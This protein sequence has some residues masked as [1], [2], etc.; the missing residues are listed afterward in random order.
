MDTKKSRTFL[1]SRSFTCF[2]STTT[3]WLVMRH[4]TLHRDVGTLNFA[5]RVYKH[6]CVWSHFWISLHL[7]CNFECVL[8]RYPGENMQDKEK[9]V[10]N[11]CFSE[12]LD[13]GWPR[14]T[15]APFSFVV[16]VFPQPFLLLCNHTCVH[17]SC[18]RCSCCSLC[19]TFWCLRAWVM[20][21]DLFPKVC[22]IIDN[23]WTVS[24]IW[25]KEVAAC[26]TEVISNV[27]KWKLSACSYWLL[28][29][30]EI[31]TINF[32]LPSQQWSMG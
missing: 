26:F 24:L 12:H 31:G 29:F 11:F 20:K 30:G 17:L 7:K 6:R 1:L 3:L 16:V 18:Q 8:N 28:C 19:L 25:E 15:W 32:R 27:G 9:C 21:G 10:A 2:K 4:V 13:A 14:L 5:N 22:L 23:R